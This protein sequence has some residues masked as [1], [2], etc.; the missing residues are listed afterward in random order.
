MVL[1]YNGDSCMFYKIHG[2]TIVEQALSLIKDLLATL[3]YL[4]LY[5]TLRVAL[6]RF[7]GLSYL[8]RIL[9]WLLPSS[10]KLHGTFWYDK[11]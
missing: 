10:G 5:G 7:I 3:K 6:M 2:F 9:Y 1:V 8:D 11:R 4:Y